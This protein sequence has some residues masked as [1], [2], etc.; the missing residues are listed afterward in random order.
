[1]ELSRE[2]EDALFGLCAV[3]LDFCSEAAVEKALSRADNLQGSDEQP[4][5]LQRLLVEAGALTPAQAKQVADQL[6]PM[7]IEGYEI[8]GEAGRGGMGVVYRAKQLSMD[9]EVAVKVLSRR[10]SSDETFVAKFLT[11]ARSAAKLNHENIVAAIN[12]GESNGLHHFVMEF[13]A[14][15][16]VAEGLDANGPIDVERAFEIA[17]QIARA[18][19]HAH[20]AGLV[21]RDVKPENIM[22]GAD[23]RAKLCDLGLA[24]PA[25]EAGTGEKSA[26]TEGTPYYC[27]PEQALGRTDIDPRS[28]VYSLGTTV[29]HMLDGEPPFDGETARAIMI[30][31][32][33]EPLPDLDKRMPD[34]PAPYRRLLETMCVKDRE[35][36]LESMRAF[37]EQLALARKE[38]ARLSRTASQRAA[39]AQG[40]GGLPVWAGV[41]LVF[42]AFAI[43][44][45][46]VSMALVNDGG[47]I[48]T[49]G[50]AHTLPG[51]DRNPPDTGGDTGDDSGGDSGDDTDEDPGD[52]SGDTGAEDDDEIAAARQLFKKA[53]DYQSS[54]P[55]DP[56]GASKLFGDV[57]ELYPTTSIAREAELEI[58]SLK[59]AIKQSAAQALETLALDVLAKLE[60]G[61]FRQAEEAVDA[62]ASEWKPRNVP[63]LSARLRRL[64]TSIDQQAGAALSKALAKTEVGDPAGERELND[65]VPRLPESVAKG[66][67]K[68]LEA[69]SAKL[70]RAKADLNGQAR[71]RA[72][73]AAG[74]E[75]LVRRGGSSVPLFSGATNGRL[76]P[77][78][79]DRWTFHFEPA[80]GAPR[81]LTL[82]EIAIEALLGLG[83]P[84]REGRY[85]ALFLL[86]HNANLAAYA[87]Y[88]AY[89][90]A[91]G[92]PDPG[93]KA[94]LD[95]ARVQA[96]EDQ[97]TA[98]ITTITAPG[99]T[100]GEI[101]A[102]VRALPSSV[103]TTKVYRSR[104]QLVRMAFKQARIAELSGSVAAL[105][106]GRYSKDR[107]GKVTVE[108]DFSA[109]EQANDFV[110]DVSVDDQ[111]HRTVEA[112]SGLVVRGKVLHIARFA[113]GDLKVTLK[114]IP[115]SSEAP[116]ANVILSSSKGWQGQLC[117]AGF[118][119]EGLKSIKIDSGARKKGGY[120]VDL[121]ASVLVVLNG[122]QPR[123]RMPQVLAAEESPTLKTRANK[124]S[125]QRTRKG[126]IKLKIGSRTVFHVGPVSGWDDAGQVAL[127]PFDSEIVVTS[128]VIS[129]NLDESWAAER[130]AE[131]ATAEANALPPP[132]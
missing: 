105:F 78:N 117:G 6:D 37:K 116:N 36:R 8:L 58:G 55:D 1:M 16:S 2:A 41:S 109:A 129:G 18:L 66:A 88:A 104:Y 90:S 91:N 83:L 72:A 132:S 62:F 111:S 21:H 69:I 75:A 115:N 65:L 94:R 97:A 23:G 93:L 100:P 56:W 76:G 48:K 39:A 28:D 84:A 68:N 77:F 113:G 32:V 102:K 57:A 92:T 74:C 70:D 51:D 86:Q 89:L 10:L 61:E 130:I 26:T 106:A 43:L 98:L 131:L 121:P 87:A 114:V 95:V 125:L 108:Y 119:Y 59:D 60:Q 71:A 110:V 35:K 63:K 33:R 67:S 22:I 38:V 80:G 15:Q 99:L 11:E 49:T 120:V 123:R 81:D 19:E 34:V 54:N 96:L 24:K 9:R 44:G 126:K 79:R 101:V 31:Q 5:S 27:S 3:K 47:E 64:H 118:K 17:E 112:D 30:K 122:K 7:V 107:K 4:K 25:Q 46:A 52:D 82:A 103:Y 14:G 13:V 53:S 40:R 127:A 73:F 128:L 45:G 20:A 124:L 12:A 29:F 42:V 50:P 85:N